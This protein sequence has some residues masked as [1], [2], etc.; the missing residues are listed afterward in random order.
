[1]NKNFNKY[2]TCSCVAPQEYKSPT[3]D[4]ARVRLAEASTCTIFP[5]PFSGSKPST[6]QGNVSWVDGEVRGCGEDMV[7]AT[8][9]FAA[10]LAL[11]VADIR[12]LSQCTQHTAS[13]P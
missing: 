2:G 5:P 12:Y 7:D 11:R 9:E 4:I 13:H 6:K 8:S 1:M 3:S 10:V